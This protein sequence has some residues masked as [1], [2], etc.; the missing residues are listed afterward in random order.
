MPNTVHELR[1]TLEDI[2]P[3]IWRTCVVPSDISLAA[4]HRIIQGVMG[5]EDSHLHRFEIKGIGYEPLMPGL[6]REPGTR[7]TSKYALGELVTGAGDS[8]AYQYDF[9]DNWVH[10]IELLKVGPPV[11]GVKYPTCTDGARACPPEDCG[12]VGGYE[13]VLEALAHPRRKEN[14]EILEWLEP[15]YDPA[16]FDLARANRRLGSL[17]TRRSSRG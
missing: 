13:A 11:N 15:E 1:I 17:R 2:R 12:G 14:K 16:A 7:D 5:W 6:E 3:P 8:F 9:G 4:L 10:R